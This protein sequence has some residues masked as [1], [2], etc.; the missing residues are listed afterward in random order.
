MG[1]TCGTHVRVV[2]TAPFQG[3]MELEVR[4]TTLAIG[5]G[6]AGQV[7]IKIDENNPTYKQ[8]NS[9]PLQKN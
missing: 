8:L 3:P 5:R 1:L 2:N 6:L 7:F 9:H 4:G